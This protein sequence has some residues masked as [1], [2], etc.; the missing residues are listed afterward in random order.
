MQ[1]NNL[2]NFE[3]FQSI[4]NLKKFKVNLKKLLK[5]QI[6]RFSNESKFKG[7]NPDFYGLHLSRHLD[8][9]KS[10]SIKPHS[11]RY[12]QLIDRSNFIRGYE[13]F[14]CSFLS[15]KEKSQCSYIRWN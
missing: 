5:I 2:Q 15:L 11:N 1:K 4:Q 8:Q 14:K 9:R 10:G 13:Y 6:F 12:G 7:S 3:R